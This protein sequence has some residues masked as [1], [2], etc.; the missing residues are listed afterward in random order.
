MEKEYTFKLLDK[1]GNEIIGG[2]LTENK[3]KEVL[4]N[5]NITLKEKWVTKY[6][7][8]TLYGRKYKNEEGYTLFVWK[9]VFKKKRV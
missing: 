7:D 3:Y 4:N 5:K 6:E 2:I 9:E 8:S 1:R